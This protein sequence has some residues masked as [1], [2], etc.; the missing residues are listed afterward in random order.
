MYL[1][2]TTTLLLLL[3]V[4]LAASAGDTPDTLR[5]EQLH[6]STDRHHYDAGERVWLRA[7]MADAMTHK[8]IVQSRYLYIELIDA[9]ATAHNRVMLCEQD[10][11]YCGYI[12][13]PQILDAERYMLRGY[14]LAGANVPALECIVPLCLGNNYCDMHAADDKQADFTPQVLGSITSDSTTLSIILPDSCAQQ[15][16]TMTIAVTTDSLAPSAT[17]AASLSRDIKAGTKARHIPQLA[18]TLTGSVTQL[19]GVRPFEP[20]TVTLLSPQEGFILTTTTNNAGR[21]A[22]DNI[23]M[24]DSTLLLLQAVDKFGVGEYVLSVDQPSFPTCRYLDHKGTVITN[25]EI[26]D[27]PFVDEK[28]IMLDNLIVTAL[29]NDNQTRDPISLL[30]DQSLS[31]RR[32][33]EIDP[34]SITDLFYRIAGVTLNNDGS[35]SMRGQHSIYGDNKAKIAIDGVI[36]EDF[37]VN[38]ILIQDVMQV[39]VYRG[40]SAL[41]WG[42]DG[43]GGVIAIYT[44]NGGNY[45]GKR[46][47]SPNIKKIFPFGYQQYTPFTPAGKTIYWNP[48][49]KTQGNRVL[50]LTVPTHPGTYITIQG[51]THSGHTIYTRTKL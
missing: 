40:G 35:I 49:V 9:G 5:L 43:G 37:D 31:L 36:M 34:S 47:K 41:I 48:A 28:T 10:G 24:A 18:Q 17:I 50:N 22:F 13:L 19:N 38:T 27:T 39:D 15:L 2:R 23:E 25:Y 20:I 4:A 51:L 26:D 12:D 16:S 44:K 21:Y 8:P 6:L 1:L 32:L 46:K 42:A 45:F 33:K 30:A 29:R 7:F 3:L 11:M 14:T